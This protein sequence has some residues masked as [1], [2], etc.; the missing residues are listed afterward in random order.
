MIPR[1]ARWGSGTRAEVLGCNAVEVGAKP[2]Q[3][4]AR[5]ATEY[6]DGGIGLHE[7]VP[8]KRSQFTDGHAV[9]GDDEALALV[10]PPHDLTALVPKLSLGDVSGHGDSVA[11]GATEPPSRWG[12]R[13]ARV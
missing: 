1:S 10:Q 3:V 9:A 5:S 7:P 2:S 8:P 11:R 13:A 6:G 4:D 12:W